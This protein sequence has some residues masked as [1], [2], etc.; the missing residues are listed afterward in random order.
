MDSLIGLTIG[1]WYIGDRSHAEMLGFGDDTGYGLLYT[2]NASFNE[3]Y[4]DG[5]ESRSYLPSVRKVYTH[6]VNGNSYLDHPLISVLMKPAFYFWLFVFACFAALYKKN[7]KSI[8]IFAY[9]LFYMMTMMLGPCVNFRY[10]Y[11]FII[12]V[13]VLIASVFAKD[14]KEASGE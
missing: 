6:I 2:F 8:I 4:P 10:M 14:E 9:P 13:P 12:T 11:P 1:Y 3:M 5:I 7:K